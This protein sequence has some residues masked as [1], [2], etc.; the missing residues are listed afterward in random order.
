MNRKTAVIGIIV[1]G[2]LLLS[3]FWMYDHGMK[4]KVK[5]LDKIDAAAGMN[6]FVL[7]GSDQ[8]SKYDLEQSDAENLLKALENCKYAAVTESVFNGTYSGDGYTL[9]AKTTDGHVL[10]IDIYGYEKLSVADRTEDKTSYYL[11][12]ENSGLEDSFRK[13]LQNSK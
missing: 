8:G 1:I 10:T 11:I 5:A 2:I 4:T 12:K 6:V 7:N 13:I 3:G 9:S